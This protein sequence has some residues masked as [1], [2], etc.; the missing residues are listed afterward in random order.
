MMTI[1]AML[2][3]LNYKEITPIQAG[4][5]KAFKAQKH[6]VGLAPTG[7]GKTHAYLLPILSSVNLKMNAVQALIIV[8]TNELVVQVE[9]MLVEADDS[10]VVKTYYGGTNK[11]REQEWLRKYQPQ[12]VIT[13]PKQLIEYV[14]E[15]KLLG[16]HT[17]SYVVFDEADMMFDEDFLSMIDR[18]LPAVH[19]AKYFL[20]SATMNPSMEPFIKAYFGS[21]DLIDTTKKHTLKITYKLINIKYQNRM[22]ALVELINRINPYLGFIFVS[23]KENQDLVYQKMLEEGRSVCTLNAS[24][25]VKKR[26]K[27]I[28]EINALKYQ[29][30]VTS[31]L[32]ARGLDFKIS[33]VIHYDLPHFLEFYMHRS[34]RTGRMYDT[35]EVIT[36]MTV[37]DH[38]KIEKLKEKG[39][40]FENYQFAQNGLVKVNLRKKV[41]SEEEVNAIKKVK[42]DKKVTPNYKK[43]R[44]QEIKKIKQEFRRKNYANQN[45]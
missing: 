37:D 1:Q 4:V 24:M 23:K 18:I 29:Y 26:S 14:L 28:E 34:G 15:M 22:D 11:M 36:F 17:A 5:F 25:G 9:K 12:I 32:A 16:I 41:V 8:P 45:R 2:D 21:Y 27:L 10:F 39:I 33:H 13:T 44:A 38:R 20:F 30:V 3:K 6:V 19:K 7:T 43:K 31:D 40:P 35:G 42:K